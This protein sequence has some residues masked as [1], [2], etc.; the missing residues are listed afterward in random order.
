[1]CTAGY[2][3]WMISSMRKYGS[4]KN[5]RGWRALIARRESDSTTLAKS[6]ICRHLPRVRLAQ[7]QLALCDSGITFRYLDRQ[8]LEVV[9]NICRENQADL[10]S[11]DCGDIERSWPYFN[12][13]K[14]S[15][16]VMVQR[17]IRNETFFYRLFLGTQSKVR[18]VPSCDVLQKLFPPQFH[19]PLLFSICRP[20][21]RISG[22]KG[23]LR[24]FSTEQTKSIQRKPAT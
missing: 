1:M 13:K 12:N 5:P 21:S 6:I 17:W 11:S 19:E 18:C 10:G 23:P 9:D 3:Q 20:T 16:Q 15:C 22:T 7:L 2:E 24:C 8:P 4:R 14:R